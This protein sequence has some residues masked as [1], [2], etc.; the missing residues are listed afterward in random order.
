MGKDIFDY[1][2]GKERSDPVSIVMRYL[3]K[4]VGFNCG[5]SATRDEG[6]HWLVT[7]G[8]TYTVLGM[9][10]GVHALRTIPE[11]F[12][13]K[14]DKRS[15]AILDPPPTEEIDRFLKEK[16]QAVDT[17]P[18]CGQDVEEV[19]VGGSLRVRGKTEK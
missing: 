11:L 9:E 14:V 13:V 7:V 17:C 3:L 8:V 5:V 1:P 16:R 10:E 2:V 4:R 19:R 12:H 18:F 6:D 15:K